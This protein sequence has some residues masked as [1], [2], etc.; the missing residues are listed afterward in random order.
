LA[1]YVADA[2]AQRAAV[3]ARRWRERATAAA[4]RALPVPAGGADA[5]A[6]VRALAGS[7]HKDARWHGEVMRHGW[8]A[9]AA[10]HAAGSA[11]HHLLKELELLVAVLLAESEQ[12]VA[13]ADDP[14]VA[15]AGA[16]SGLALARRV[17]RSGALFAESAAAAYL[18]G[19]VQAVRGRWRVLRHDLRNPLGTIRG[20]LSLME[21]EAL[22]MEARTGPKMRDM[23]ARNAGSMERLIGSGLGDDAPTALLATVDPIPL[24]ELAL[25]VRR[26]LREPAE[27]AACAV[28]VADD[29]QVLA[30]VD[31][32]TAELALTAALLAGL[33]CAAHGDR[34]V[35]GTRLESHTAVFT[36]TAQ[37]AARAADGAPPA[38]APGA[39][40]L[41]A[42]LL[43]DSGGRVRVSDDVVRLE[44]P[45]VTVR[46]E[47]REARGAGG[48][49][50]APRRSAAEQRDDV[51]RAD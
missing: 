11:A 14:R 4:P 27:L 19:F 2:L 15:G 21:D 41:A 7:L 24:R 17:H 9:G 22:P 34:L 30:R 18:H 43:E 26:A 37:R 45:C 44:L 49:G 23:L 29:A 5:E 28:V 6:I 12:I 48:A 1:E 38:W 40:E 51:G 3:V 25:A 8:A 39:I 36:L 31:A 32:G 13:T 42:M 50:A 46:G 33:H 35:V 47:R 20:A 16:A 10:A